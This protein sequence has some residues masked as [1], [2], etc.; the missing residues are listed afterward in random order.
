MNNFQGWIEV[1]QLMG[2]SHRPAVQKSVP[3]AFFAIYP[4][5]VGHK[6]TQNIGYFGMD[7]P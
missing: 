5:L 4:D 6:I 2:A 3:W 7:L 1:R